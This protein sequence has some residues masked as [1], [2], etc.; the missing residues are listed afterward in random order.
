[1]PEQVRSPGREGSCQ[2]CDRRA[3]R[4]SQVCVA[5]PPAPAAP[6]D[7]LLHSSQ[8]PHRFVL[9]PPLP[10]S[11][12]IPFGPS[13]PSLRGLWTFRPAVPRRGSPDPA[14]QRAPCR[15]TQLRVEALN[16]IPSL[17][18]AS[19]LLS[20]LTPFALPRSSP[21]SELEIQQTPPSQ[22]PL[23]PPPSNPPR[24]PPPYPPNPRN[25]RHSPQ[26]DRDH[27]R[28]PN[29]TVVGSQAHSGPVDARVHAGLR[30]GRALGEG[31]EPTVPPAEEVDEEID[32]GVRCAPKTSVDP[33]TTRRGGRTETREDASHTRCH[34]ASCRREW[35]VERSDGV[36]VRAEILLG[37]LERGK[38]HAGEEV[39]SH[40]EG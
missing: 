12:L 25:C 35:Q 17:L 31:E 36:R 37:S 32:V 33:R 14:L 13:Q 9:L 19:L 26:H 3:L 23:N 21:L 5:L 22:L 20:A 28:P 34:R 16:A 29:R 2:V 18:P 40:A 8:G 10:G 6:S 38:R 27:E 7:S 11:L 24:N 1:M 39:Q 15:C 4:L 30:G